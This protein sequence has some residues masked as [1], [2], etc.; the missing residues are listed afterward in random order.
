M[1][2]SSSADADTGVDFVGSMNVS[3][4]DFYLAVDWGDGSQW[5][6]VTV[7]TGTSLPALV[8]THAYADP[9]TYEIHVE[10]TTRYPCDLVPVAYIFTL[11]S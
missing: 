11:L 2:R 4:C 8:A 9:G 3:Y 7:P 5:Q 6:Y 1:V 10:G